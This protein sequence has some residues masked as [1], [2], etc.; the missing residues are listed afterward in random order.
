MEVESEEENLEH[1]ITK[2]DLEE[3][4]KADPI[5]LQ[6]EQGLDD[7]NERDY[8]SHGVSTQPPEKPP[9][10]ELALHPDE[11]LT[12]LISLGKSSLCFLL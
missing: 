2:E 6:N 4:L 3:A 5:D 12:M 11:E 10:P 7:P 9:I 1:Y 8:F